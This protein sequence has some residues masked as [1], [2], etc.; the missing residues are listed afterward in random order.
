MTTE[1]HISPKPGDI[2]QEK[3]ARPADRGRLY[4]VTCRVLT[5]DEHFISVLENPGCR[6]FR[7][8]TPD[9]LAWVA[10]ADYLGRHPL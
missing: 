4:F 5:V 8:P 6:R 9:F 10:T 7:I 1:A 2:F 3:T